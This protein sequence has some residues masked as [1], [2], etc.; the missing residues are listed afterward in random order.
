M[1]LEGVY[2][3]SKLLS[4][5]VLFLSYIFICGVWF[6]YEFNVECPNTKTSHL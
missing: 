1:I 6:V 5:T 3:I 2:I 4:T